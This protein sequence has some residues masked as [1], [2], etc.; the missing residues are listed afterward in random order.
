MP[1]LVNLRHLETRDVRLKGELPVAELDIATPDEMIR[2]TQPLE[3]DLEAQRIEDSLLVRGRVRLALECECVRC[4]KPVAHVIELDE[5]TLLLELA[6]EEAT[7]IENDCVDLTP[8]VREDIL[9]AFPQHPLCDPQCS[10]LGKGHVATSKKTGAGRG[11]TATDWA[12][13]DKL[14]LKD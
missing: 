1:L 10:G 12:D 8:H 4:L 5:F 11:K 3:Y 2:A 7:P 9:L 14:K 6:G 13:L